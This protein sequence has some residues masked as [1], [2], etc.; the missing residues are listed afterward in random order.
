MGRLIITVTGPP[1]CGKTTTMRRLAELL[2]EAGRD[3]G[4]IVTTEVRG[5]GGERRGFML[6]DIAS[7]SSTPLADVETLGPR[8]GKYG[9]NIAGIEGTGVPAIMDALQS[10]KVIIIDEVGPMELMSRRF[11]EAIKQVLSKGKVAVLTV[12]HS[13]KHPLIDDVKVSATHSLVLHRGR[14]EETARRIFNIIASMGA[15]GKGS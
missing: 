12:H 14:S 5:A 15:E 6:I 9:V 3:V 2:R 1:G 11:Q 13:A 7:G 4:G 10:E 8:V